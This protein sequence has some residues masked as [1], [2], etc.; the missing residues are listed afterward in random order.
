MP[1]KSLVS[2]ERPSIDFNGLLARC[3]LSLH[4][5]DRS[6]TSTPIPYIAHRNIDFV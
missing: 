6:S 4:S 2:K 3:Q 5:L 1:P